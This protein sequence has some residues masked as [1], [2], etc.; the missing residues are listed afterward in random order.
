[1]N[2]RQT[3]RLAGAFLQG[4]GMLP[5]LF[6]NTDLGVKLSNDI[7]AGPIVLFR[8]RGRITADEQSCG[9]PVLPPGD[10]EFVRLFARI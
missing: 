9:Y 10:G 8:G 4:V 5:I 6:S 3:P 1:L 2:S 7:L